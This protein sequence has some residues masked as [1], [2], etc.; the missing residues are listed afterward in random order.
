MKKQNIILT[1]AIVLLVVIAAVI[2]LQWQG[3]TETP[4]ISVPSPVTESPGSDVDS[5]VNLN[6]VTTDTVQSLIAL[7]SKPDSYSR[8]FTAYRY[9]EG[10]EAKEEVTVYQRN[11]QLRFIHAQND[12]VK[13]TLIKEGTAYY[14]NDGS[15]GV[16]SVSFDKENLWQLDWYA[17]L[18]TYEELLSLPV[19]DITDA[20]YES[21]EGENYI[22]VEYKHSEKYLYRLYISV[23]KGLLMSA[24]VFEDGSLIYSLES[25]FTELTP[26]GDDV[27]VTP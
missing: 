12:R 9:W 14:W 22:F 21:A 16:K 20:A 15:A 27:F 26:P 8:K 19:E 1:A 4:S 2:V 24:E 11:D 3:D 7:L 10:G 6:E 13:N 23:D 25:D 5:S 18:I 17:G